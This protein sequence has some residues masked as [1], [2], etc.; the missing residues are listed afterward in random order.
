MASHLVF[1]RI[2]GR[3]WGEG[4]GR[5]WGA[6]N[7]G[8]RPRILPTLPSTHQ[9]LAQG[10]LPP[11]MPLGRVTCISDTPT[12]SNTLNI[13]PLFSP[14]CFPIAGLWVS[15]RQELGL[16]HLLSPAPTTAASSI[17]ICCPRMSE[18]PEPALQTRRA[19]SSEL[20]TLQEKRR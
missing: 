10:F 19:F 13:C 12:A 4:T 16:G 2:T 7:L 9:H 15:G 17:R 1:Q 14:L 6:G 18:M 20:L 11:L 8:G 3:M 5:G